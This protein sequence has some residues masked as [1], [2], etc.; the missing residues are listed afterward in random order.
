[1][2]L[3]IAIEG[4]EHSQQT[5]R[6]GALLAHRALGWVTV[7]TVVEHEAGR[8]E[9]E[10]NL[11]RAIALEELEGI[12]VES[13]VR[14][15]DIAG[16]IVSEARAGAYDLLVIGVRPS[17]SFLKRLLGPISERVV[18]DAPCPV[19]IVKGKARPLRNI[20]VCSSGANG[21]EGPSRA[22][23]RLATIFSG[24]TITL[25]HVMSQISA[26]PDVRQGWQLQA[27]AGELMEEA[28]PE[29]RL[30]EERGEILRESEFLVEAKVRHGLVVDEIL[31]EA[32]SGEYDLVV[33]GS[34]SATGW[35]RYLLDDV[36]H[37]I[38]PRID[39]SL[40][41]VPPALLS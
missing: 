18:A 15:G 1:M 2:R 12:E 9:A 37:Q 10:A 30:L 17:H 23:A 34:H 24:K 14:A 31:E 20:L 11:A 39:S 25:L 36:A 35:R 33:L 7:L 32:Q 16:E 41:I 38:I 8:S 40:L 19:L 13:K 29:G 21:Y 27:D 4:G 22:V 6:L 26:T 3:L 5:V 28:T